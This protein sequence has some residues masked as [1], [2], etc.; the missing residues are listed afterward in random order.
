MSNYEE[1]NIDPLTEREYFPP[2]RV[3]LLALNHPGVSNSTSVGDLI[4]KLNTPTPTDTELLDA[5]LQYMIDGDVA[6][7][8]DMEAF[9]PNPKTPLEAKQAIAHAIDCRQARLIAKI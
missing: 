4:E 2:E 9:N 7:C 3:P 8:S 5:L 6:F 1:R